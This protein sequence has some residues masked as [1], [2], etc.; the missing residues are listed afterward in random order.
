MYILKANKLV[1]NSK[2]EKNVRVTPF[3]DEITAFARECASFLKP[4]IMEYL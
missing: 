3:L 4:R 2:K 1:I